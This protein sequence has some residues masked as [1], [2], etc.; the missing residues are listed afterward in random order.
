MAKITKINTSKLL[1]KPKIKV[2]AYARVSMDTDRLRHSLSTQ[3]SYYNNLIQ[4]NPEWEYV[5]V[6]ADLGITGTSIEKRLEFKR[7][8]EDCKQGKIDLI[9]TKSIQRFARNTVD[10]LNVV[11][12]LK[13]LGIEVWFEKENI[14]SLS[15]DGELMLSILASFAQEESRSISE[16]VKWGTIKRFKQGIPNGKFSIY[17]Y[18]WEGE[19]LVIIEDEAKIVRRIYKEYLSGKSRLQI[20][21]MFDV[22]GI[23]TRKG[24]RWVDSNIKVILT[25]IHYTGNLL[26][27]KEYVVDPISGKTR[28]N[29]GELPQ[30]FV[31]NT[32]EA[33]ISMEDF[34][35]VET[36]MKRRRNAGAIGN[37]SINTTALTSKIRCVHCQKNFQRAIRNQKEAKVYTWLCANRKAGKKANC[38]TGEIREGILKEILQEALGVK[39]IDDK[40]IEEKIDYIEIIKKEKIIVYK[41]DGHVL[42]KPYREKDRSSYYTKEIRE[43]LSKQRRDKHQYKRTYNATPFTGLVECGKCANPYRS[44]GRT[45]TTGVYERRMY[46]NTKST[47][48][49]NTSIKQYTLERII[50]DVLNIESFDEKTMDD[51][52]Q[53]IFINDNKVTI[54]LKNG[55]EETRVYKEKRPF[56]PWSEERRKNQ[57][58]NPRVWTDEERLKQS[59]LMKK[60]RREKKWS[61]RK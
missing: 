4:E 22:E 1:I 51:K 13:S 57:K 21:K 44:Q 43:Q 61:T 53:R 36:E 30:Y 5:G 25:N 39:V 23:K 14:Q 40:L 8:M 20:E 52:V 42:E 27:Q 33:I 41:N 16:N 2:A 47:I 18:R 48:C 10:L 28:K 35:K 3:I 58:Q 56:I 45:L 50:C 15:G 59:E 11:R 49:Q 24:Y 9:L 60:V 7:M 32:H 17:G 19:H 55:I 38:Q 26:F 37:P 12:E 6:Y 54:L 29:R 34:K 31:E 46:C